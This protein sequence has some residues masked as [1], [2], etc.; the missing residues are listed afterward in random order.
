MNCP[1]L[2][3]CL[4]PIQCP[5]LLWVRVGPGLGIGAEVTLGALIEQPAG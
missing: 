4:E 2:G 1:K 3:N 5:A